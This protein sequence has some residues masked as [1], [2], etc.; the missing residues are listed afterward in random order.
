MR[1]PKAAALAALLLLPEAFAAA[2]APAAAAADPPIYVAFLWHMHQPIYWPYESV[3]QTEAGQRYPYSVV[4]IHSQRSGPYTGWPRDAVEKGI[5]AGLGHLGAQVSLSG[6]LIENLDALEA[7][8]NPNFQQWKSPWTSIHSQT[9]VLGH[10]R[11]DLVGFGYHHPLMGLIEPADL[12]RQIQAHRGRLASAFGGATSRGIFPPENAFT[13]RMIPALAAEGLEWVLVDNVHFD[14]AATAYPYSTGGNLVEPNRADVRNPDPADWVQLSGVWAPTPV[15]GAWGHRPHFVQY[16]DPASGQTSR[17]IAVPADRYLGNED[18]RGGFGALQYDAVM[19]QLQPYNTDPAHPLLVVLHHD[20]DNYGG[21]SESYYHGNFQAFVDWLAANPGRFVGTTVEDYLEMFPPDT[22]DVIHVENGSWSGADNG[23]P[24]FKKWLGDP[25]STGYSPDRNSWAVVTAARNVVA[26]AELIAPAASGT[27][28]AWRDLLNAEASDYW[29]WDGAQGGIWDAHP[30]RAANQAVLHAQPVVSG[31]ADL[32]GPTVFVPQREPYNPGG[33]EWTIAQS[34][35]FEVW[36]FAYDVS[37]LASVTLRYR[38]DDDGQLAVD[39]AAND[40]YAGGAGVGA[41]VSV[42]CTASDLASTTDPLPLRRAKR[43]AARVTGLASVLVDYYIEAADS[44][45][46]LSR[47]AIQHVWVGAGGAG[48]TGVTVIPG[49]PQQ[50][51]SVTITVHGTTQPARLHWGVNG[52]ATPIPAYRPAGTTLYNGTG[53]AVETPFNVTGGD[54][55]LTLGPFA[56]T[57]QAVTS[58]DFVIH[59]DAGAWDNNG[60]QDWHVPVAGGA[61]RRLYVMDGALDAGVAVAC[62][63]AGVDLYLDW[64]GTELYAA[65]PAAGA[66]GCDVFILVAGTRGV[67]RGAP[68]AKAGQIGTWAAFLGNESS[69]NW[70]GWSDQQGTVGKAAASFLEGTIDLG[71]ELGSVPPSVFVA[72]GRYATADGGALLAQA[73]AGNGDANLD[74]TEY[75]EFPLGTTAVRPEPRGTAVALLPLAPTPLHGPASITYVLPRAAHVSLEVFD[76][77]GRRVAALVDGV[78]PAGTR[79]A[80]WDAAGLGPGVYFVRLRAA[81]ESITRR[82][83]VIR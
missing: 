9:T 36:T 57:G 62:S 4:D 49:A 42:A 41:W 40:T 39:A 27:I 5:A 3:L 34:G 23:D 58:L 1:A 44:L 26:T 68:W 32:A 54:L 65:T 13:Q 83:V 37:G 14:R 50:T 10:P 11:V 74:G 79:G 43:Y 72:V 67:L 47:S 31:G 61:G 77:G 60:G 2:A 35:D 55:A 69:N 53:P 45:G 16:R 81:G 6:S 48:P 28:D 56:A 71:A 30:T 70:C 59:Y 33:T 15:S 29:Y 20:G 21:G 19:S 78:E 64:N 22:G 80:R 73:P 46:N 76:T 63:N 24:E 38:L 25:G 7:G 51:D 8:G 66:A 75:L 18:G 17:M 82:A 12:R 52:F